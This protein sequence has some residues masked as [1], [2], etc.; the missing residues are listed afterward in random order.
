MKTQTE[1]IANTHK[2]FKEEIDISLRLMKR[3]VLSLIDVYFHRPGIGEYIIEVS[4]SDFNKVFSNINSRPT[5][6]KILTKIGMEIKEISMLGKT[7]KVSF[8][9]GAN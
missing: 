9:T 2:I 8:I 1:L 4:E 3:T 7:I 6:H 5:L